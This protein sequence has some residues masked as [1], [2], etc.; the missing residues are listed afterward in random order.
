MRAPVEAVG[1]T[2]SAIKPWVC[3]YGSLNE[4]FYKAFT[5][6]FPFPRRDS[7]RTC[8]NHSGERSTN[9]EVREHNADNICYPP[10]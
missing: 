3:M 1:F 10:V 5:Y 6:A 2:S 9:K 8:F 4:E 7:E